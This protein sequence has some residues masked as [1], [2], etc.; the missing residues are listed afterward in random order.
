[1]KTIIPL[2]LLLFLLTISYS[3]NKRDNYKGIEVNETGIAKFPL[4][5]EIHNSQNQ[6]KGKKRKAVFVRPTLTPFSEKDSPQE[7]QLFTKLTKNDIE[8]KNRRETVSVKANL[9]PFEGKETQKYNEPQKTFTKKEEE[10]K[11][12]RKTV[13]I[14]ATLTPMEK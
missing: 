7:S 1:M 13:I 6:K 3:Q 9:I 10:A 2:L 11:N 12:T 4:N 5:L 14:E 8:S